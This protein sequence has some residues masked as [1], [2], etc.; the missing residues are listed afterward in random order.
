[1]RVTIVA[2]GLVALLS[3]CGEHASEKP[4]AYVYDK[5]A[6]R[7]FSV[8]PDTSLAEVQCTRDIRREGAGAQVGWV[9][10]EKAEDRAAR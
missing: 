1:M 7:C 8:Q 9:R 4:A 5:K 2:F 3:G 6:D 10:R